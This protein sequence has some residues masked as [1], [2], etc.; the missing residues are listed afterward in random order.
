M[1]G[2]C[3][4]QV[5]RGQRNKNDNYQ[6]PYKLT[7][8][9]FENEYFSKKK[10]VLEPACGDGAIVKILNEKF[11]YI[12]IFAGDKKTGFDF[13]E[14]C[15]AK[16]FDYIITNPP[17]T[18]ANQ[19]ILKAKKICKIKFAFLM[20]LNYLQGQ[21]RY[22]N[23]FSIKDK[24]PLVRIY[25]FTRMPTLKDTIR[26]DGKYET[27]MQAMAWYIWEKQKHETLSIPI[28]SWIDSKDHI[29]RKGE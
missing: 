21:W 22:E 6:T 5:D 11:R 2:K 29:V 25:I 24:F 9:L 12:N 3:Y 17:F 20:K 26:E 23:I 13:L 19:F 10:E 14:M 15:E 16:I 4:S 1:K 8:A 28:I 7:E 27:G 18:L